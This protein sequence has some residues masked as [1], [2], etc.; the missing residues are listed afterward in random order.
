MKRLVVVLCCGECRKGV[1]Y[2]LRNDGAWL[3][4][5]DMAAMISWTFVNDVVP[6]AADAEMVVMTSG[7]NHMNIRLRPDGR[8]ISGAERQTR[9]AHFFQLAEPVFFRRMARVTVAA[10]L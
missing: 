2:Y 10:R 6:G 1:A 8:G 7:D 4:D 3:V 9:S 5:V